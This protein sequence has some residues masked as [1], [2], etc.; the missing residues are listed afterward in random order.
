M[1]AKIKKVIK[2][3]KITS[4]NIGSDKMEEFSQI[5]SLIVVILQVQFI[6]Q[7]KKF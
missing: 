2:V 4:I 7:L 3:V 6:I 1:V 5:V